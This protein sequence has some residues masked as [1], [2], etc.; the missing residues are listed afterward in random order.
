MVHL[1]RSGLACSGS[2]VVADLNQDDDVRQSGSL[3]I[4]LSL[5]ALDP[6][7][8]HLIPGQLVD[9]W[10]PSILQRIQPSSSLH[11]S[12]N[13][14]G[15]SLVTLLRGPQ[16]SSKALAPLEAMIRWQVTRRR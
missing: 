9:H 16:L 5:L 2:S 12:R 1:V 4:A 13:I 14:Q 3:G 8:P 15:H 6:V 10:Y 11:F 7:L